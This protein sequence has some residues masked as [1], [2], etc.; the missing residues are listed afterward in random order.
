M[1]EPIIYDK[2]LSAIENE[3]IG[4]IGDRMTLPWVKLEKY[5]PTIE[6]ICNIV[7]YLR[8]SNKLFGTK[9][10]AKVDYYQKNVY[11]DPEI[12]RGVDFQSIDS[13]VIYWF[14]KLGSFRLVEGSPIVIALDNRDSKEKDLRKEYPD[15][16][17]FMKLDDG[18][19]IP[20]SEYFNSKQ[21]K[22]AK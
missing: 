5:D 21:V 6:E 7:D 18:S 13:E 12:V 15:E 16:N 3:M 10:I 11:G 2:N 20:R 9:Y 22:H 4:Q 8:K 14:E 19:I 1:W 17:I